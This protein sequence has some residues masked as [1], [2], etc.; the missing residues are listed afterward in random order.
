[1]ERKPNTGATSLTPSGTPESEPSP[2]SNGEGR[3]GDPVRHTGDVSA[4]SPSTPPP[5]LAGDDVDSTEPHIDSMD[6]RIEHGDSMPS[7]AMFEAASEDAEFP[8]ASLARLG[9]TFF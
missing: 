6:T 3:S 4:R 2:L 1:V 8:E 9:A 5:V 7:P